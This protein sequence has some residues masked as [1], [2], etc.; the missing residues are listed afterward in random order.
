[1]ART[2]DRQGWSEAG[3]IQ[4]IA[5]IVICILAGTLFIAVAGS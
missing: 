1:M 2:P 3:G 4:G 5:F